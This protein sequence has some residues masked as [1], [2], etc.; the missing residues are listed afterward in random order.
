M[1]KPRHMD[2]CKL[3]TSHWYLIYN[4]QCKGVALKFDFPMEQTYCDTTLE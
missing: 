1:Y 3:L 2:S 4:S